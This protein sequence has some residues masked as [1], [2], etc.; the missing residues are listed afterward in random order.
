MYLARDEHTSLVYQLKQQILFILRET[1]CYQSENKQL[2]IDL[3]TQVKYN[4]YLHFF[5]VTYLSEAEPVLNVITI[6]VLR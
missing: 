1:N 2:D 5:P 6:N 3:F 4:A